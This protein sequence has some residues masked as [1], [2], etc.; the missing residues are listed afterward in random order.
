M[1]MQGEISRV[2]GELKR[3]S[4]IKAIAVVTR[5]GILIASDMPPDVHAEMFAAMAAVMLSAAETASVELN[6]AA[7]DRLII[8]TEESKLIIVSAGER[9]MLVTLSNAGT[10]I[11]QIIMEMGRSS[12]RLKEIFGEDTTARNK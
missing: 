7:P 9:T 2:I 11:G 8:E 4:G 12:S 6:R 5:E 10:G 3:I 1:T